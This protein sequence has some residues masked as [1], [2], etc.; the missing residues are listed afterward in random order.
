MSELQKLSGEILK[1]TPMIVTY[2]NGHYEEKAK[3]YYE[4]N[5]MPELGKDYSIR[6]VIKKNNHY[7]VLL[8]EIDNTGTIRNMGEGEVAFHYARFSDQKDNVLEWETVDRMYKAK[9]ADLDFFAKQSQMI[10]N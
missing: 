4:G 5:I 8:N 7:Y 10:N 9:M 3:D 6:E 2:I 1:T